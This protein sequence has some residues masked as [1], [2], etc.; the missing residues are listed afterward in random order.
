[1]QNPG[2]KVALNPQPLPP[3][4]RLSN[5]DVIKMANGRVPNSMLFSGDDGKKP[6]R[7]LSGGEK[8]IL[9]TAATV[10]NLGAAAYLGLGSVWALGLSSSAALLTGFILN[11]LWYIWLGLSLRRTTVVADRG[12]DI[13][14]AMRTVRR[15]MRIAP[16]SRVGA[17]L[18]RAV[19]AAVRHGVRR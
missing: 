1:M 15:L 4:Q 13:R 9:S 10:E 19:H 14:R 7:V 3:G 12:E 17:P 16:R 5:A 6:V 18:A 11:P 8:K 2:G